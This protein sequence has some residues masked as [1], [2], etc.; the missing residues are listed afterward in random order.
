MEIV[1]VVVGRDVGGRRWVMIEWS[2]FSV[3][4]HYYYYYD[5]LVKIVVD[6]VA[7]DGV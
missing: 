2:T 6:D 4:S 3:D 1:I 5:Y 7:D